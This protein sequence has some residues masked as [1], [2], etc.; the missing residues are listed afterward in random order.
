MQGKERD[1]EFKNYLFVEQRDKSQEETL[2]QKFK[3]FKKL[4]KI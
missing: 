2:S 3:N 1:I 4:G